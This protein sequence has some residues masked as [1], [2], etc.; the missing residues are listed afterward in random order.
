MT[1]KELEERLNKEPFEAFRIN[2]ADG[3]H[4]DV[5]N[6]RSAVAMDARIFIAFPDQTWTLIALRQ[7]TSL[8][9]LE[10]A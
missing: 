2:T 6:L 7:V 4:F 5:I 9:R 8:Q 10:A 1:R 3:K